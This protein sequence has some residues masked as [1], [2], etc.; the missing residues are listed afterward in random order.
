M[1]LEFDSGT[2]GQQDAQ[3]K[4]FLFDVRMF[5]TLTISGTPSPTLTATHTNGGVQIKG[6][7]SGATGLVFGSL[8]S[9]T[10]ITLTNVVGS[11]TTGEKLIASDSALTG[12][13]IEVAGG[14]GSTDITIGS[15]P[16]SIRTE[17]FADVRQVFMDDD[18][19]GQDFTADI[20]PELTGE[21]GQL[22]LDGTTATS[23]DAGDNIIFEE[24]TINAGTVSGAFDVLGLED[25][26]VARLKNPEKNVA[27][28]KF[29]KNTIK[30]LLTEDNNG[31]SDTQ[32]TVRRQFIGNTN[33][34]GVV[35]FTAGSNETFNAFADA[36][37]TLSILTAGGGT[38]VQGDI[39]DLDGKLS[40]TGTASLTVTDNS[41]LGNAAKVK[42]T[43]TILRTSVQSKTKTTQLSKQLKV[44]ASDADGAFGTRATDREISLGRADVFRLQVCLIQRT[45]LQMQPHHSLLFLIF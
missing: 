35:T 33:S 8:T 15:S 26:R 14:D 32:F 38:G 6:A 20:V 11:F 23:A 22:I 45:H 28:F 39:V 27:L 42:L 13:L 21:T 12:G 7:T 17:R 36:D 10:T 41:I 43:A 1:I 44:L 4:L 30:T 40:G 19:S 24:G 18:D 37:Y 29:P 16:T 2:A 3:Y 25:I 5:T 9:G 31:V 34:S